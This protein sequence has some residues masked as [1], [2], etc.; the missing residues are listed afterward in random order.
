MLQF[1]KTESV[2]SVHRAFQRSFGIA[3]P[4][5]E[6]IRRWYKQ[7]EETWPR[8]WHPQSIQWRELRRRSVMRT[9]NQVAYDTRPSCWRLSK[10]CRI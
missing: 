9:C 2:I 10:A 3:G 1:S 8:T 6:N 4:S 5:A 7:F